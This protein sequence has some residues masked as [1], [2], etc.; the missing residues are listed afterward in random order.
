MI[1]FS[2]LLTLLLASPNAIAI[3]GGIPVDWRTPM[4][5]TFVSLA[6]GDC[7]GDLSRSFCSGVLLSDR[8]LVTAAHC[9]YGKDTKRLFVTLGTDGNRSDSLRPASRIVIHP[10]Y[11]PYGNQLPQI[12]NTSDI[13]LLFFEGGLPQGYLPA[14]LAS[15]LQNSARGHGVISIAGFG[16]PNRG[17]LYACNTQVQNQNFSNSEIEL[18]GYSSCSPNGGDSGGATYQVIGN[19]IVLF[20][21]HNWGWSNPDGTPLYSVEASIPYYQTWIQNLIN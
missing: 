7:N 21:I 11:Q 20:G 3:N 15:S 17:V 16:N 19:R 10:S 18:Y 9:L 4:A 6:E 1:K 8:A 2:L 12:R 5:Q 13:A 14:L